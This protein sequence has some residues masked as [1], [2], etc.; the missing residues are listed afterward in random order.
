MNLNLT[1][2]TRIGL[3][4][5][6]LF[7]VSLALFFGKSVFIPI[8]IA[9]ILAVILWPAASWLTRRCRLSWVASCFTVITGLIV[10]NLVVFIGISAAVPRLLQDMPNPNDAEQQKALYLRI[11]NS[12]E[13]MSLGSIEEV[14]P[15]DPDRSAIFAYIKKTLQGEFITQ[16]LISLGKLGFLWLWQSVLILFILLFLLL[17][18]EMLAKRIKEIFGAG[19]VTQS[20]VTRIFGANGRSR[21]CLSGLADHRELRPRFISGSCL[22]VAGP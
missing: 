9:A 22:P 5:L 13:S 3:N 19:A 6:A 12:V 17:E 16:E 4:I 21:K 14:L 18:G 2:A 10:V 7:G 11:R 20:H 15:K 1:H 8:V